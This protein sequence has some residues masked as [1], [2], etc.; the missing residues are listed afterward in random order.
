MAASF[1]FLLGGLKHRRLKADPDRRRRVDLAVKTC[2]MSAFA[3]ESSGLGGASTGNVA[4]TS[5]DIAGILQLI[6]RAD[7]FSRGPGH[8]T[9]LGLAVHRLEQRPFYKGCVG[10]VLCV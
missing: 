10:A 2:F 6:T 9:V 1:P 3:H 5:M 8:S 7:P 4:S